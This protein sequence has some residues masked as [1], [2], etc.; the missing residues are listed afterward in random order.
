[1]DFI[2]KYIYAIL[3]T[4]KIQQINPLTTAILKSPGFP[5]GYAVNGE[6]FMYEIIKPP[7]AIDMVITFT[8]WILSPL[9]KLIVSIHFPFV[10]Y[11]FSYNC[12]FNYV[13]IF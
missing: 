2:T 10:S 13:R 1:M 7:Y 12:E 5:S 11:P 8:D 3:F 4:G 9:S 6:Q